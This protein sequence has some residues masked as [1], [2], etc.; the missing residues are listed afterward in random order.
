[1]DSPW[2]ADLLGEERPQRAELSV[3]V[4][5]IN[6][7]GEP[8]IGHPVPSDRRPRPT[9]S[10]ERSPPKAPTMALDRARCK[11]KAAQL[12]EL[13]GTVVRG[14]ASRGWDDQT[15]NRHHTSVYA[16]FPSTT[17]GRARSPAASAWLQRAGPHWAQTGSSTWRGKRATIL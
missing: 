17:S 15:L 13:Q 10:A 6:G 9:F 14:A 8:R 1:M 16:R 12:A 5:R 4:A 7:D 3:A 2:A 11:P